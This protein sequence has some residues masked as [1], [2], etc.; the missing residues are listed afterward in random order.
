MA[1]RGLEDQFALSGESDLLWF[2]LKMRVGTKDLV[3]LD[4]GFVHVRRN[5]VILHDLPY[6]APCPDLIDAFTMV[7]MSLVAGN[8]DEEQKDAR[9]P[10]FV[11]S[12]R[13]GRAIGFK[14]SPS[15][16]ATI[17]CYKK[18]SFL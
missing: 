2:A 8:K 7:V 18:S 4:A 16:N 1:E 3:I 13:K 9:Q 14:S 17:Y 15:R 5:N 10:I 6:V 11:G 12:L